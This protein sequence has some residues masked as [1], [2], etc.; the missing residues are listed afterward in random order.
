MNMEYQNNN[1][2]NT[3][4]AVLTFL[5]PVSLMM[6]INFCHITDLQDNIFFLA[7]TIWINSYNIYQVFLF[8][9]YLSDFNL[10]CAKKTSYRNKT[11]PFV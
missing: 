10:N 4:T 1:S 8:S 9:S 11:N 7:W 5:W 6:Q 3:D 2:L